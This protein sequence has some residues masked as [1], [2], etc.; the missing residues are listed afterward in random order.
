MIKRALVTVLATFFLLHS[1]SA[2]A[3]AQPQENNPTV[4]TPTGPFTQNDRDLIIKVKQAGLWEMPMG[5]LAGKVGQSQ[6]VKEVGKLLMLDHM[7]LDQASNKLAEQF[8]MTL[9]DMPTPAQ[10]SWMKELEGLQGA[11]FDRAF[12]DRL[13]AA[14]GQV[15]L[16]IAKVRTQTAN[17]AIRPFAQV[18][19][20][21]VMKHMTLL[22]STELVSDAGRA[23]PVPFG[24]VINAS[25][26]NPEGGSPNMLVILVVSVAGVVTTIALLRV[27]RPRKP[28]R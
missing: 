23:D 3:L 10:Q 8:G 2:A 24:G 16:F 6:R 18:G 13:R 17:D 7:K 21:I 15:F 1:G 26:Q 20:D 27:L 9:P 22:E 25:L 4:D 14:H 28:V 11:E 19:I 12:A 5:E